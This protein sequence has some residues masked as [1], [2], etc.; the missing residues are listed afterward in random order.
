MLSYQFSH[1]TTPFIGRASEIASIINR[2]NDPAC[3]L[4]TLVGPGGTGKTRLSIE[5]ASQPQLEFVDEPVF[6]GLQ[7]IAS[8]D[9]IILDHR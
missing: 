9:K 1:P 6:V 7:S 8:S 2:L 5:V 3:R 4:L